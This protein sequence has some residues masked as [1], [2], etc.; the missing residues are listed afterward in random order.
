[1]TPLTPPSSAGASSPTSLNAAEQSAITVV[2][3]GLT[4]GLGL[5]TL[6]QLVAWR[7][8][9]RAP[10]FR[11]IIGA[12]NIPP[13]DQVERDILSLR[14]SPSTTVEYL[15]LDLSS[16][17]SVETFSDSVRDLLQAGTAGAGAGTLIDIL[18]LCAGS[19]TPAYRNIVLPHSGIEVEETLYVNVISQAR[20]ANRLSPLIAAKGRISIVN[21][22]LH[23]RAAKRTSFFCLMFIE[24]SFED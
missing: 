22:G 11:I 7:S 10:T 16:P 5:E 15:P 19:T 17:S 1:M 13:K 21:S 24:R 14:T 2:A 23:L 12:R 4:S 6:K 20:L 18:L 8:Q 9:D 3:T